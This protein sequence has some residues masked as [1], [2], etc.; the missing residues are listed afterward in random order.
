MT[1][2][3]FLRKE[4]K[5]LSSDCYQDLRD[6]LLERDDGSRRVVLPATFTVDHDYMHEHHQDTVSYVRLHGH[7]DIVFTATT[8]PNWVQR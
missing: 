3:V 4:Q 8:N 6:A 7:S 1:H 2:I 5:S